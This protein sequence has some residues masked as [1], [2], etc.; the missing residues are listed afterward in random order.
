MRGTAPVV[1]V[2]ALLMSLL[3]GC[4]VTN[5]AGDYSLDPSKNVGV[6][7][8]SL[9]M[10]GRPSAVNMFVHFRGMGFDYKNSVPVSDLFASADWPCPFL[11][12]PTDA[13]PCGRLAVIELQ[14]GE[15]EFYSW[16]GGAGGAPGGPTLSVGSI[17][18]FSKRCSAG[19]RSTSGT[20]ISQSSGRGFSSDSGPT[21]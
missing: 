7:V 16:Q 14:P 10:S 3:S 2:S 18:P 5:I 11:G 13:E 17:E 12:V 19:P 4:R 15:Y 20:S 9:T 1:L 6:A 8:V 21:R